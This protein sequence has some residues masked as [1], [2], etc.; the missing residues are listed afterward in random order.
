MQQ[1]LLSQRFEYDKG[2]LPHNTV[3]QDVVKR[4]REYI[5]S[6]RYE[7]TRVGCPVCETGRFRQLAEQDRDGIWHSVVICRRCGLIQ[8]NP[9]LSEESYADFYSNEY[10]LLNEGGEEWQSE[11]FTSQRKK[12]ADIYS[13]LSSEVPEQLDE[14]NILDVGT[15]R[16]GL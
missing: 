11:R 8:T 10:R 15:G 6:G 16:A 1:E 9:R 7:F 12:A 4:V 13:L 14:A 3:Q 5:E 2:R